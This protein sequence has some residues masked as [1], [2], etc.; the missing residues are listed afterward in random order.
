MV[1]QQKIISGELLE[2]PYHFCLFFFAF[3]IF[4][5][6]SRKAS[7]FFFLQSCS[8][9]RFEFLAHLALSK[10]LFEHESLL[11]RENQ[12]MVMGLGKRGGRGNVGKRNAQV[13]FFFFFFLFEI[14]LIKF[15]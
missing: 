11:Q 9:K 4:F 2:I 5:F 6:P 1:V 7:F 15:F 14:I 13:F 10:R 8:K 12:A 3:F